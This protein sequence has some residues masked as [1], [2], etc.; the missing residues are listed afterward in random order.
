MTF[1][2]RL[3]DPVKEAFIG[4]V[5]TIGKS[6]LRSAAVCNDFYAIVPPLAHTHATK[7]EIST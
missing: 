3:L 7:K 1:E 5:D 6:F 2:E 4:E